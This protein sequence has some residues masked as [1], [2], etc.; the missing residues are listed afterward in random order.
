MDVLSVIAEII[1]DLLIFVV[2]MFALLIALIVIVSKMPDNNPLKRVLTALSYRIGCTP[3]CWRSRSPTS[4]P[5]SPGRFFTKGAPSSASRPMKRTDP[6]NPRAVLGPVKA[7]PGNAGAR[8]KASATANLDGPC[9]RRISA[10]A[11]RDE[12]TAARHEQRNWAK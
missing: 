6:L 3:T 10:P 5:A 11:G 12:G 2:V 9:A 1:K 8:G 7:W 4:S